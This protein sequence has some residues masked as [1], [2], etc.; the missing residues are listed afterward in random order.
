[1]TSTFIITRRFLVLAVG[2]AI[3]WGCASVP[4]PVLELE[5]ATA[6]MQSARANGAP[7][8]AAQQWQVAEEKFGRANQLLEQKQNASAQREL[9]Q[10]TVDAK[11]AMAMAQLQ[12]RVLQQRAL[13][14]EIDQLQRRIE[15][16]QL[17]PGE[18]IPE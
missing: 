18:A 14:E 15:Q 2:L 12:Q 4:R 6:A 16:V 3:L 13:Q 8:H 11:L 9:Q 10:A 17:S 5:A 7:Q 1:M